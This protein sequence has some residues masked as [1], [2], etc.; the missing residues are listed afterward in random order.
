M[1][2]TDLI[3]SKRA[4]IFDLYHTLTATE[5][6]SPKGLSTA[7]VLGIDRKIWN[8]H[9]MEKSR[10]RLTGKVSDA[11]TIIRELAHSIDPSIPDELIKQAVQHRSTRFEE[12]LE[13]MPVESVN[14]I[15]ALK[16]RGKKVALLSNADVMETKGW[17]KCP[18]APYFDV[19]VFS[20]EVGYMKPDREIY[21]LCLEKLGEEPQNCVFVGD[22]G[23][24]EFIGA[25]A[26]G[27]STIMVTGIAKMLW[28]EKL[29]LI[30]KYADYVIEGVAELNS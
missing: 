7:T 28:P 26:L 17:A 8:E 3:C 4:I 9:L 15:K 14:T 19:V 27:I 16:E 25:K 22:G 20:C 21:E 29:P 10:G 1:S 6:T 13:L 11:Y 24:N 12:S 23:S 2:V 30:D 18:G 5:V